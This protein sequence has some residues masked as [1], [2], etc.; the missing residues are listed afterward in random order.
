ME[1]RSRSLGQVTAMSKA[2]TYT[3]R[4]GI[5]ACADKDLYAFMKDM[6]N[7]GI[8]IPEGAV[9]EWQATEDKCSFRIEKAGKIT[10][11]LSGARPWSGIDYV[12]ETFITGKV[13]VTLN[14]EPDGA[15]R[16][17]VT[18]SVSAFLNPF[19]KIAL[20]NK[21]EMFLNEIISA[22]ERFDGYDKIR[23]YSQSL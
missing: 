5:A 16:S 10:A 22:V 2:S 8:F 3:S 15:E 18:I 1:D 17:R 12:A 20:G 11:E 13:S 7:F 14:I 4:S 19:V 6:R 21:A 23:G 9:S